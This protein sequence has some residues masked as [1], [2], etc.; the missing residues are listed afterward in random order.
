M[1]AATKDKPQTKKKTD[2]PDDGEQLD[3]IETEPEN[4]KE[5]ARLAR[6]Y[7][8][9]QRARMAAGDEEADCKERLLLE[10]KEAGIKSGADGK[11][12]FRAGDATITVTP[13]DELVSV[14]FEDDDEGDD[15]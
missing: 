2:K 8:K 12:R 15:D 3:L 5:V 13:R 1:V 6:R 11:Y 7:K 4:A 9:A 10:V 14:K